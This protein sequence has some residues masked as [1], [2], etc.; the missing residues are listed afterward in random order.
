MECT[1]KDTVDDFCKYHHGKN[2]CIYMRLSK[3]IKKA[4][5]NAKTEFLATS[6]PFSTFSWNFNEYY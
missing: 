1:G 5:Y 3:D 6:M 2:H 4:A